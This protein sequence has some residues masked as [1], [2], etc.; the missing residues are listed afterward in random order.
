MNFFQEIL[1][2]IN[3]GGFIDLT[4]V[5]KLSVEKTDNRT[6]IKLATKER[7]WCISPTNDDFSKIWHILKLAKNL[8]D[9]DLKP[10]S[11]R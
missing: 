2:I 3:L 8:P 9:D 1:A 6:V 11:S 5:T 10:D 4:T 7:L